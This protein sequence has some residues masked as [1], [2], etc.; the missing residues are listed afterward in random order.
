[1]RALYEA[2]SITTTISFFF[3]AF[4]VGGILPEFESDWALLQPVENTNVKNKIEV[5]YNTPNLFIEI[6]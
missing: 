1:M 5:E 2:E 6:F 4:P 3:S